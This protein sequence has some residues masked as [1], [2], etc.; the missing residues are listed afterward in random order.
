MAKKKFRSRVSEEDSRITQNGAGPNRGKTRA[1]VPSTH[2][3][4]VM[5]GKQVSNNRKNRPNEAFKEADR[6]PVKG[7]HPGS[8]AGQPGIKPGAY[9]RKRQGAPKS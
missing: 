1:D 5:T 4:K 8:G 7:R 6:T 9:S 3:N 2:D